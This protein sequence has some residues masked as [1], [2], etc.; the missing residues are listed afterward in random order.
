MTEQYQRKSINDVPGSPSGIF[1]GDSANVT[2]NGK[3]IN[4]VHINNVSLL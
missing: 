3:R 4:Y 1:S 2:K